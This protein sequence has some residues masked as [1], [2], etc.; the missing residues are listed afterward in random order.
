MF[1]E[2]EAGGEVAVY[3]VREGRNAASGKGAKGKEG[4][5]Q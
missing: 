2:H 3:R 4:H 1:A 5:A